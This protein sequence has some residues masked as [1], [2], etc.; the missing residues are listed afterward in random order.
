MSQHRLRSGCYGVTIETD[1]P[2]AN[3]MGEGDGDDTVTVVLCD[4]PFEASTLDRGGVLVA[5]D[6]RADDD[7]PVASLHRLDDAV[8]MRVHSV[9]DYRLVDDR[10]EVHVIDESRLDLIE[11]HVLGPVLSLWLERRGVVALHGSAVEVPDG[12]IGFLAHQGAGKSTLAATLVAAG[13]AL[14]A[15]DVLALE[16]DGDGDVSCRPGF[17][18][19]RMW[20]EQASAFV[21]ADTELDRVHS[22]TDK[23]RVPVGY[24][25]FGTFCDRTMPLRTLYLPEHDDTVSGVTVEVVSGS[26]ALVELLRHSFVGVLAEAVI[27]PARIRRVAQIARRVEVARLRFPSGPVGLGLVLEH[28]GFSGQTERTVS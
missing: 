18:I 6:H 26:D 19:M 17:P 5:S 20:P 23:R 8:V 21:G 22:G 14:L 9:A 24:G 1:L 13:A 27:G 2:L 16:V 11:L 3:A 15:D 25:G 4:G 7:T 12:A 10:I 28:L